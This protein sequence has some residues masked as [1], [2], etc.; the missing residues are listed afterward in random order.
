MFVV[1]D[2]KKLKT[3]GSFAT[4]A[5]AQSWAEKHLVFSG[6]DKLWFVAQVELVA[7]NCSVPT[8]QHEED[9]C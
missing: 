9:G 4:H 5:E 2:P 8:F 6:W 3:Y 7:S 1:V